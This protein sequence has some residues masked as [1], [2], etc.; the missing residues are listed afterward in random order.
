MVT[1][2]A[3]KIIKKAVIL[4][5]KHGENAVEVIDS[6]PRLSDTQRA[7]MLLELEEEGYIAPAEEEE[8]LPEEE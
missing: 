6:Y 1:A 8:V 3:Y 5:I 7:Q 2:T 4:R